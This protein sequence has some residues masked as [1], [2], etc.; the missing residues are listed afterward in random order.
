MGLKTVMPPQN[1]GPTMPVVVREF[2]EFEFDRL[3]LGAGGWGG[4]GDDFHSGRIL[5]E[6]RSAAKW[7][8]RK[9][10]AR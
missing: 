9:R 3:E 6:S 5:V 1:K 4:V 7:R 2:A 10:I 8:T